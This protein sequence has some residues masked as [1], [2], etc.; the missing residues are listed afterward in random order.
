MNVAFDQKIQSSQ[1]AV[2]P[3]AHAKFMELLAD[4]DDEVIG[5]RI[6]VSGGGC[7]GMGY[8]MTFTDAE[9]EHDL[10]LEQDGVKIFVD[11]IAAGFMANTEIDFVE[12]GTGASFVFNNAFA[13]TSSGGS[14]GG[15]GS[16]GGGCS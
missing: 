15:C 1:L 16:S 4:A 5:V 14:C 13:V 7:S 2:T 8:G 6:Y 12:Q 9:N 11:A 3:G 10:I